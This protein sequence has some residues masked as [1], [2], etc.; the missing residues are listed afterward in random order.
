MTPEE[1]HARLA[2]G[3]PLTIL[4]TRDRDEFEAWHVDGSD[5]R[6][7]QVPHVRFIQAEVAGSAAD[8]AAENDLDGPVVAVCAGGEA[9]DH[10]AALLRDVGID[11]AN[12]EGGMEAWA[13]A[14][15]ATELDPDDGRSD[16]PSIRQYVRPSSGC[17]A[18]LVYDDGEA[19]LVEVHPNVASLLIGP[20][21]SNL[22][23]LE[24]ETGKGIFIRGSDDCHLEDMHLRA[25]G[26]RAE[27]EAEAL[28][29]RA[30]EV[31]EL[32]IE[33]PH[34][35]NG[36]DGIARIEGYVIDVEG[37]ADRLGERVKVE[38]TRA[39]RTY[40]RAKIV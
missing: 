9:S 19:I 22:K 25:L 36:G 30:G 29:V 16:G 18:Y 10:A 13:R 40:A 3:E 2:R 17:L 35:S 38:I 24:K 39:F 33:E 20:S 27:V 28:P 4:D 15:V 37:G 8:L 1:L 32:E 6:A 31:I 23:E 26:D 34:V 11:A 12:L 5:V 7:I 21:G 14:Y